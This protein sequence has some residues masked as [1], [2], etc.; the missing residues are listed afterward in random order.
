MEQLY[1]YRWNR[2]GLPGRKGTVC[3]VLV[4]GKMNSCTV[5]FVSDGFRAVT[6]RNALR[7]AAG[8][9]SGSG[10]GG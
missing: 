8:A 6:S 2:P 5:E 1:E 7:K 9:Q 4:R 3:R 10:G